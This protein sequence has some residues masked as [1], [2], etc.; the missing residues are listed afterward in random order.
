MV[1]ITEFS[2][3]TQRVACLLMAGFVVFTSLSVG[4]YQAES[5]AHPAYSVTITQ[6]Q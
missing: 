1:A 5:V 6:V 2:R 3:N 4:A